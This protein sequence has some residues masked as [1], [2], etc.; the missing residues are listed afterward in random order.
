[1]AETKKYQRRVIA[2]AD[3]VQGR[4]AKLEAFIASPAFE[5]ELDNTERRDLLDQLQAMLAYVEVL[6][7]RIAYFR[8]KD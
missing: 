2:E 7:R 5:S 1:M 4:I 6:E 3:Q 8:W